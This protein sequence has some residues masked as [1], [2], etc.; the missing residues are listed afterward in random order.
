MMRS[1]ALAI[2]CRMA[3]I[4]SSKPA[5]M[6]IVSIRA[7][8]SRGV[9]AWI[10]VSEPSWPVFMAWSM[11]SVSGSAALADDDSFGPHTQG[12]FHQVGGGDCALAF[13]VRRA[14]FQPHDVVLLELKFGRVLDRDDAVAVRNEA[15][16]RVEQRRFTGAGAAGDD[17]VQAGL[18]AA[19]RAA[20]PSRA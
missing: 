16:Q 10:V 13:D 14:R 8:A 17:H 5:I 18:D 11:S 20:S 19:L 3:L 2:C 6:I 7:T 4:G 9:L 12:V 15:G 1:T